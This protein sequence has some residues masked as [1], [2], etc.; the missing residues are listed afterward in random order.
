MNANNF[1]IEPLAKNSLKTMA[2]FVVAENFI[3]HEGTHYSVHQNE[4]NNVIKEEETLFE[5]S[6]SFV[7]KNE[8]DQIVGSIRVS[9]WNFID[10]LPFEKLFNLSPVQIML[11]FGK[12]EVWHI[13]RFAIK[14]GVRQITLFK[15]LMMNAIAPIC[16]NKKSIAFAECDSKLLRTLKLL[17]IEVNIV[18]T[19][20]YYLGSQTIPIAITSEGLSGFY[21]KNIHLLARDK[22]IETA[23]YPYNLYESIVLTQQSKTYTLV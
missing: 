3:H 22:H 7:A 1:Y 5:T 19:P 16:Q 15:Q 14:S 13:G 10:N 23:H 2:E 11:D 18:G 6:A 20:I 9:K 4:I 8:L 21:N 17:G 12:T